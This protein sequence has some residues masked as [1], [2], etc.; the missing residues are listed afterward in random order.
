MPE[1]ALAIAKELGIAENRNACM[2]GE[3][4]ERLTDIELGN[5]LKEVRVFARVSPEHKVRI[6]RVL[7]KLGNIVAMTGDGVNDAPSLRRADIGICHGK[8]RNGCC[9]TGGRYD[10]GG[11]SFCYD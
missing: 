6:V 9:E 5:R 8:R 4:L 2:T 10:L 7:K 3:E 11:R 1:T